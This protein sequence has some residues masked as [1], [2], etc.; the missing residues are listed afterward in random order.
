MR[1]LACTTSWLRYWEN[2]ILHGW[3]DPDSRLGYKEW[4]FIIKINLSCP[5]I[6]LSSQSLLIRF[7]FP[8]CLSA[9]QYDS[10]SALAAWNSPII[11]FTQALPA[12]QVVAEGPNRARGYCQTGTVRNILPALLRVSPFRELLSRFFIAACNLTSICRMQLNWIPCPPAWHK[13]AGEQH[14]AGDRQR[15]AVSGTWFDLL[16]NW[17]NPTWL[18]ALWVEEERTSIQNCYGK[19]KRTGRR[20]W[21]L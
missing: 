1:L 14:K 11:Q 5:Y 7:V 10:I 2:I 20:V 17:L 3:K 15:C 19:M 18:S 16:D 6:S 8:L 9:E 21:S 4:F 13:P 12:P